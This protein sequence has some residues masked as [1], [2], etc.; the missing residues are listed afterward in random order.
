MAIRKEVNVVPDTVVV[1]KVT[2]SAAVQVQLMV[3]EVVMAA[4]NVQ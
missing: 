3:D 2:S 1:E 4:A